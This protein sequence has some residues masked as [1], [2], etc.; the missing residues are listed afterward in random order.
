MW[1]DSYIYCNYDCLLNYVQCRY[2]PFSMFKFVSIR[3]LVYSPVK[4]NFLPS[5][6]LSV[7]PL[8]LFYYSTF[9]CVCNSTYIH[10]KAFYYSTILYLQFY[11]YI[12]Q[13]VLLSYYFVFAILRINLLPNQQTTL[14]R[15]RASVVNLC[16]LNVFL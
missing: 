16:R 6:Q 1:R 2:L 12:L 7:I 11:L 14:S 8:F 5:Y 13:S 4:P 15:H 9:F 3:E 10:C